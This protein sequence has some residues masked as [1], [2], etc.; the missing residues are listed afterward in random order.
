MKKILPWTLVALILTGWMIDHFYTNAQSSN[1]INQSNIFQMISDDE[2]LAVF[3]EAELLEKLK[4]SGRPYLPFLNKHSLSTGIYRLEAGTIDEQN[5]HKLDE[6]YYTLDGRSKF[7]VE[8]K[9]VDVKPGTILFVK[10][11]AVHKFKDITEDLELLVF[12]ST[13][14]ED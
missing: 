9:T 4:E 3:E 12:F 11:G 2:K 5:P 10:A 13:A 14:T 7:E 6:V 8:G 1:T